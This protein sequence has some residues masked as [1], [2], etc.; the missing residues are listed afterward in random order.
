MKKQYASILLTLTCL[1]GLGVGAEGQSQREVVMTVP[2]QFVAGGK[3]LPAGT[4]TVTRVSQ[5]R[6]GGLIIS[7]YEAGT[8][9]FVMPDEFKSYPADNIKVSF[10]QV[11]DVHFLSKIETADGAY[12]IPVPHSA[13]MVAGVKHGDMSS[14]GTN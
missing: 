11:G 10:K 5:D 1:L 4:Y 14:S 6:F 2:Y 7:S 13:T 3:T 9:V 8:S 12:N